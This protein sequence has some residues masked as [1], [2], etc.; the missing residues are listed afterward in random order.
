[1]HGYGNDSREERFRKVAEGIKVVFFFTKK[2][3]KGRRTS[4]EKV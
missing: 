3:T 1:M 2:P 4:S